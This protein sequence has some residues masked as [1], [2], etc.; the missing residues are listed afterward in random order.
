MGQDISAGNTNHG[1]NIAC[2]QVALLICGVC[3]A[4]GWVPAPRS[5]TANFQ[6]P[7][8]TDLTMHL[9]CHEKAFLR[10]ARSTR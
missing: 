9:A 10:I 2:A 5:M 6:H 3:C 8:A 7:P 1:S 4:Y